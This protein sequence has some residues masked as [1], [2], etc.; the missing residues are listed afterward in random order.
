MIVMPAKFSKKYRKYSGY[1]VHSSKFRV[2][3]FVLLI[4]HYRMA[5]KF[6]EMFDESMN[7]VTAFAGF[8]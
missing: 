2:S 6:I 3:Y 1:Q 4:P 5:D 7:G 8:S